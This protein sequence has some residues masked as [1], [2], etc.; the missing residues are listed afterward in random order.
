MSIEHEVVRSRTRGGNAFPE[1]RSVP[2]PDTPEHPKHTAGRRPFPKKGVEQM[3]HKRAG[4]GALGRLSGGQARRV[5]GPRRG[6]R[7]GRRAPIEPQDAAFD[8]PTRRAAARSVAA[9]GT[10]AGP[11]AE[12][13]QPQSTI[14][15]FTST[16]QTEDAPP[17]CTCIP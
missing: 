10:G 4:D 7:Q 12:S 14:L 9:V 3:T 13:P 16:T 15:R 6:V 1:T 5:V 8:R 17:I 11:R 2:A